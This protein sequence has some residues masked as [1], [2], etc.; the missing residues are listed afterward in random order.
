[1]DCVARGGGMNSHYHRRCRYP[2]LSRLKCKSRPTTCRASEHDIDIR[3]LGHMQGKIAWKD[4]TPHGC[5]QKSLP[6]R[7]AIQ[8][9]REHRLILPNRSFRRSDDYGHVLAEVNPDL[10]T[11]HSVSVTTSRMF[12]CTAHL[13]IRDPVNFGRTLSRVI[14]SSGLGS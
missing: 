6:G 9:D 8:L 2:D 4:L 14:S 10:R 12:A 3:S 13:R 11:H 7:N 5:N 1:V